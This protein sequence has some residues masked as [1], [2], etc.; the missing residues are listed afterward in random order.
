MVDAQVGVVANDEVPGM[1]MAPKAPSRPTLPKA[2]TATPA[3]IRSSFRNAALRARILSC[4]DTA[5][6]SMEQ[7][8]ASV[9]EFAL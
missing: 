5:R 3:V 2:L 4:S 1:V 6:C 7:T 8:I 9:S